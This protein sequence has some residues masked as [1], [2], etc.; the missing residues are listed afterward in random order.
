ML[1]TR[2][3]SL[4]NRR[5]LLSC[6]LLGI[7]FPIFGV[8]LQ[9]VAKRT[10]LGLGDPPTLEL[11]LGGVILFFLTGFLFSFGFHLFRPYLPGKS[12]ASKAFLYGLMIG[13]GIYFGNIVNFTAFDPAGSAD[14]FSPYKIEQVLTAICD[15][16]NFLINGWLLGVIAQW[17]AG[18]VDDTPPAR[19]IVW[20][21]SLAG[22]AILPVIGVLGWN[23][24]TPIFHVEYLVPVSQEIWFHMV[25]WTPLAFTCGVVIPLM[26]QIAEPLLA[27][28]WIIKTGKF[29]LLHFLWYWVT[30]TL[31]IVPVGGMTWRDV[32]FFFAVSIPAIFLTALP[33]AWGIKK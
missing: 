2:I 23:F 30:L 7:S 9:V 25:F 8:L 14:P 20:W 27:G 6:V 13:L 1:R 18:P 29:T 33:A 4:L 16:A 5:I 21:P 19:K 12:I 32:F 31:F 3:G 28:R 10:L 17:T 15:L 24:W 11:L 22:I 26:Y